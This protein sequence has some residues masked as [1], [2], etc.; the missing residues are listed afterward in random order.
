MLRVS[1]AGNIQEDQACSHQ[2]RR[3][4]HHHGDY[5]S[6]RTSGVQHPSTSW[7]GWWCGCQSTTDAVDVDL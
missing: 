6:G 4:R 7:C 1:S 2:R 5:T 3:R